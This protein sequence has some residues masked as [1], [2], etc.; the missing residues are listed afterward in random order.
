M[1]ENKNLK[2]CSV[3]VCNSMGQSIRANPNCKQ[4]YRS[5]DLTEYTKQAKPDPNRIIMPYEIFMESLKKQ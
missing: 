4:L 5:G 1:E 2:L 3:S